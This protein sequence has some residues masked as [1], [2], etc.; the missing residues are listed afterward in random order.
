MAAGSDTPRIELL[1][2]DPIGKTMPVTRGRRERKA[3]SK[4]L[5]LKVS[6]FFDVA[7]GINHAHG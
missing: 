1:V 6:V 3:G 7:V 4:Y 2:D 5:S